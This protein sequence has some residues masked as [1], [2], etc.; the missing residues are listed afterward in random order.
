MIG[1]FG[2]QLP[3]ETE[4]GATCSSCGSSNVVRMPG[5]GPH[6]AGLWCRDCLAHRW[7]P[8]PRADQNPSQP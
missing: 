2:D 7:L 5:S 3:L 8:K 1:M 4:P 6:Y